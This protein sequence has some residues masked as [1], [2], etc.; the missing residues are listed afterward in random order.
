MFSRKIRNDW[1]GQ[2]HYQNYLKFKN[3]T[4]LLFFSSG[5]FIRDFS[6]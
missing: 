1:K 6:S 2:E 3:H 4:M 5:H